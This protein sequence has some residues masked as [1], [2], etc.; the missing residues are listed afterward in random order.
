V[1]GP[2]IGA[3]SSP[4]A[5]VSLKPVLVID[6]A[7]TRITRPD[8]PIMLRVYGRVP[9]S[10]IGPWSCRDVH[11]PGVGQPDQLGQRAG[12]HLRHDPGAVHLDRL[13]ADA[14]FRP[15]LLV[16]PARHDAGEHLDLAR[17]QRRDTLP[18]LGDA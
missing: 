1:A 12:P 16:Q 3:A 4:G 15:D 9:R 14:E 5:V 17:R 8:R 6:N 13:L 10:S 18:D 7:V 2:A 11:A